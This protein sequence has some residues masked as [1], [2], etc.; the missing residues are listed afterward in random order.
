MTRVRTV[1]RVL[2]RKGVILAI[3][4]AAFGL[5]AELGKATGLARSDRPTPDVPVPSDS[6]EVVRAGH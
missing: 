2:G 5:F 1:A 4:L 6:R 3:W